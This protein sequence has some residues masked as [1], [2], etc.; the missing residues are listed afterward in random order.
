M[1]GSLMAPR[2]VT[3]MPAEP[4]LKPG[5]LATTVAVPTPAPVTLNEPVLPEA[6][7]ML[8]GNVTTPAGLALRLTITPP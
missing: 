8:D 3:V 2:F 1:A 4:L 5:T 6:I 7:V